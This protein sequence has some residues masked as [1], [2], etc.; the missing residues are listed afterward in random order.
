[1]NRIHLTPRWRGPITK[2]NELQRLETLS[3]LC[4][5]A[6][7]EKPVVRMPAKTRKSQ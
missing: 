7:R 4:S 3:K 1:M 5:E 6:G 2:R